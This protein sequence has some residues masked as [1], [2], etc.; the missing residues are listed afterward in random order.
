LSREYF[1]QHE[2]FVVILAKQFTICSSLCGIFELT[3]AA[4]FTLHLIWR[5]PRI[6]PAQANQKSREIHQVR[7]TD[8]RTPFA[9]NH[10]RIGVNE[11]RPMPGK[12]VNAP[13][14]D[15]QQKPRAV[16]VIPLAHA[17]ERLAA[18]GME[19][20]RHTHKTRRSDRKVCILD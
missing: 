14:A 2:A 3:N 4:E 5:L 8:K 16:T 17:N 19:G 6:V 18:E 15:L 11:V 13:I 10:P 12:R 7:D 9:D 1:C 20:V